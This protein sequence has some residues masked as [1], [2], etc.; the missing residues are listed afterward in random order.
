[1]RCRNGTSG[2]HLLD[3]GSGAMSRDGHNE[4]VPHVE[5]PT[6]GGRRAPGSLQ[7]VRLRPRWQMTRAWEAIGIGA[8][9][10]VAS[11]TGLRQ[12]TAAFLWALDGLYRAPAAAMTGCRVTASLPSAAAGWQRS[13]SAILRVPLGGYQISL[14]RRW[15][16]CSTI[17]TRTSAP[18]VAPA[19]ES[20]NRWRKHSAAS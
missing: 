9:T 8:D 14:R 7:A 2:L 15:T 13:P 11:P 4:R 3:Q 19:N 16:R 20:A 10:L 6:G 18:A 17:R 12:E 1:M 5:L